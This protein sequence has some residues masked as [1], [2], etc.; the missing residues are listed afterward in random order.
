VLFHYFGPSNSTGKGKIG[1]SPSCAHSDGILTRSD[2][3]LRRS[4]AMLTPSYG[5][6]TRPY[7]TLTRSYALLRRPY[8]MLTRPYGFWPHPC[9]Y[10]AIHL[11]FGFRFKWI[12]QLEILQMF[13]YFRKVLI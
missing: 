9:G 5:Y 1:L 12:E 7:A 11:L 3:V 13:A 6:L 2:E 8:G 10:R 4:Y